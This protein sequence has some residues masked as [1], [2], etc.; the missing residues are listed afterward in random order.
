MVTSHLTC[1]SM[2]QKNSMVTMQI[3]MCI[4]MLLPLGTHLVISKLLHNSLH[5]AND[6]EQRVGLSSHTHTHTPFLTCVG[7]QVRDKVPVLAYPSLTASL[8]KTYSDNTLPV[9]GQYIHSTI[10]NIHTPT[11]FSGLTYVHSEQLYHCP[12]IMFGWFLYL[13]HH[14]KAVLY[15]ILQ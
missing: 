8:F 12:L 5:A 10:E 3:S 13:V 9:T 2:L 4:N 14:L 7:F 11:N 15:C 1:H 6:R